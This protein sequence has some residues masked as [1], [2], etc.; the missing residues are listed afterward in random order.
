MHVQI[1]LF[2]RTL[3]RPKNRAAELKIILGLPPLWA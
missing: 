2:Y 1:V 3:V